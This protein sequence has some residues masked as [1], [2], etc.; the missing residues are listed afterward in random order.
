MS[1]CKWF[2]VAMSMTSRQKQHLSTSEHNIRSILHFMPQFY[3][4]YSPIV[5]NLFLIYWQFTLG[6]HTFG[7]PTIQYSKD[8]TWCTMQYNNNAA[9]TCIPIFASLMSWCILLFCRNWRIN[10]DRRWKRAVRS[11]WVYI[12]SAWNHWGSSLHYVAIEERA[13]NPSQPLLLIITK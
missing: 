8:G 2:T 10:P 12:T 13:A 4:D 11:H 9:V 7:V 3:T 5:N 6:I 1:I